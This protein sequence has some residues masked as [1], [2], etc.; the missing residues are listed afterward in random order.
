MGKSVT[1]RL[2]TGFTDPHVLREGVRQ[3]LGKADS[4]SF[5]FVRSELD[6]ET[7]E[8]RDPSVVIDHGDLL[9]FDRVLGQRF[10]GSKQ[11]YL[12]V[13]WSGGGAVMIDPPGGVTTNLTPSPTTDKRFEEFSA[14]LKAG[15]ARFASSTVTAL[16]APFWPSSPS[17]S[18]YWPGWRPPLPSAT[19]SRTGDSWGLWPICRFPG[20]S[21]VGPTSRSSRGSCC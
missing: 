18:Q 1:I 16:L 8:R 20:G 6:W 14:K 17:T 5:S 9:E 11:V 19:P 10:V 4:W 2:D 12:L 13:T 21:R 3:L 15:A 7:G